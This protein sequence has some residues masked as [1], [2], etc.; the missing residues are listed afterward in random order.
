LGF[1][2]ELYYDER[3]YERQKEQDTL[4]FNSGLPSLIRR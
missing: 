3:P 4:N 1:T 2:I